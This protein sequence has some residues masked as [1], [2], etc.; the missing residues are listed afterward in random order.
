MD[1]EPGSCHH[2]EKNSQHLLRVGEN[3]TLLIHFTALWQH[4][5][6]LDGCSEGRYPA[7]Q[8]CTDVSLAVGRMK[9]SHASSL[10]A[11]SCASC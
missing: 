4:K 1:R 6:G 7:R 10:P 3:L 5:A 9:S 2:L 11:Q 8:M